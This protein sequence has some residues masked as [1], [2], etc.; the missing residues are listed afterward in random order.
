[1]PSKIEIA[2]VYVDNI[3]SNTIAALDYLHQI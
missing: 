1:M 3:Q 2:I